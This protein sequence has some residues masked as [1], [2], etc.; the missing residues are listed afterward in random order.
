MT[1]K[2]PRKQR[3]KLYNLKQHERRAKF[4]AALDKKL[5]NEHKKN[6]FPLIKGDKVK[7]ITG[8]YRGKEGKVMLINTH[9]LKIGVEGITV[10]KPNGKEEF[11]LIDPSNVIITELKLTDELR[12]KA[13]KRK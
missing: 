4:S 7:I 10:K 3:K 5:K 11:V 12:K 6:S 9:K 13:L 8:K 2:Q 1:S